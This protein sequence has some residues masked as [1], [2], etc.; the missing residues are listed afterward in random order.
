[1]VRYFILQGFKDP[2]TIPE[3]AR[4]KANLTGVVKIQFMRHRSLPSLNL[5]DLLW[6]RHSMESTTILSRFWSE[7]DNYLS[8]SPKT[9]IPLCALTQHVK[10][11]VTESS[12]LEDF[13]RVAKIAGT[14]LANLM[15]YVV[16]AKILFQFYNT[17]LDL[18]VR[19]ILS[20]IT[21]V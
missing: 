11:D 14:T 10:Y 17:S 8:S 1:M 16:R 18:Q 15:Y 5:S 2:T 9:P 3:L 6:V 21:K 4:L 7:V 12:S 13:Q 19:F 20:R